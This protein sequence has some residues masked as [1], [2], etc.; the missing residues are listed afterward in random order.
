[1]YALMTMA[2]YCAIL[3]L[4]MPA[5]GEGV[6]QTGILL[7]CGVAVLLWRR[8]WARGKKIQP[9]KPAYFAAAL[10]ALALGCKFY[11]RWLPSSKVRAIASFVHLPHQAFIA[12]I[13]AAL[14]LCAVYAVSHVL[15]R[16][17]R[18]LQKGE[19]PLLRSVDSCLAATFATVALSQWM[20][21]AEVF[22]MGYFKFACGMLLVAVAIGSLFLLSGSM[23]VSAVLGTSLFMLLSTVNVYVYRFRGRLFEPVDIFSLGT[24]MNVADHYSLLPIPGSVAAGWGIWLGLVI[25]YIY[26]E[27]QKQAQR[28]GFPEDTGQ[29]W[30]CAF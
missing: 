18:I 7:A 23:T 26:P 9:S 8:P 10:F 22:S 28:Q 15:Q 20:I 12:A 13:A 25:I 6:L 30:R 17:M 4:T 1:M 29:L 16:G 11:E 5:T 19:K 24:A 2:S 21:G 14:A 27:R 3:L